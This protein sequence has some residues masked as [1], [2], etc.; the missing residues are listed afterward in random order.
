M[1]TVVLKST[2]VSAIENAI[3]GPLKHKPVIA[4]A[5]VA[6]EAIKTLDGAIGR[7]RGDH[8]A[9]Q[10]QKLAVEAIASDVLSKR[11]AS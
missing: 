9:E 5:E 6:Q 1:S 11:Y 2:I 4:A 10:W 3:D 7:P 8:D